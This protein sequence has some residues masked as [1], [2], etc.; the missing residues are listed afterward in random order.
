MIERS[1][2]R[3]LA[4]P[5]TLLASLALAA[6]GGAVTEP[7]MT[8]HDRPVPAGEPRSELHLRVDLAPAQGCEEA[9]DLAMYK[10]LGVDLV[11]WDTNTGACSGRAV[12]IR[13][14]PKK[15]SAERVMGAARALAKKVDPA[16]KK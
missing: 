8:A 2:T 4:R 12:V 5:L 16:A 14:L 7:A 6:C 10:D 15:T 1:I 13:Y 11:Q 9:F 3:M